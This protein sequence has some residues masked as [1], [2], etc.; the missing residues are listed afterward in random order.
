[1]NLTIFYF[2]FLFSK[3]KRLECEFSVLNMHTFVFEE[4]SNF[5]SQPQRLIM[6]QCYS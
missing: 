2:Y 3:A 4:H 1:M 6:W 5:K